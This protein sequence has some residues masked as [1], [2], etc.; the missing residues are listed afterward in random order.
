MKVENQKHYNE[1][2]LA[3]L[4]MYCP[5]TVDDRLYALVSN[6]VVALVVA[7]MA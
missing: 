4:V 5:F 1:V 6:G 7:L 3:Y 2:A